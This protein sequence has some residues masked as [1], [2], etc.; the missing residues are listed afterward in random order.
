[1][2]LPRGKDEERGGR[3]EV[4]VSEL[5]EEP[6]EGLEKA[7]NWLE[8]EDNGARWRYTDEEKG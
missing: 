4:Q 6:V 8:V 3:G 7:N 1:M 2:R 5:D